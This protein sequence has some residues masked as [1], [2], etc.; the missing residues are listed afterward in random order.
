MG[1]DIQTL[2]WRRPLVPDWNRRYDALWAQLANAD[3]VSQTDAATLSVEACVL[4]NQRLGPLEQIKINKLAARLW[5]V[6]ASGTLRR[7]RIAIFG[8]ATLSLFAAH[9]KGSALARGM[10][11]DTVES[12]FGTVT[13]FA[14][15]AAQST[16]E[17]PLDAALLSLDATA[18]ARA[19]RLLDIVKDA[20]V[21]EAAAERLRAL[22]VGV[23]TR[24]GVPVIVATV[25]AQPEDAISS[26]EH[27]LLGSPARLVAAVNDEVRR[28]AEAGDW[29]MWDA[30]AL[31][32]E[33]GLHSW[34]DPVGRHHAKTPFASELCPIAA[35]HLCRVLAAM[36]GK[37]GRALVLDLDNTIWG[38][39]VGDDGVDGIQLGNGS[40]VGEAF[41]AVQRLALEL[42]RRGVVLAV[43]SKNNEDVARRPFQEHPDM[44]LRL[45]DI[46]VFQA[47]WVDKATNLKAIADALKLG[48]DAL[49][50]VDDNP[51]ERER[52]RQQWPLAIVPELG[53]EPAYFPRLIVASGA[54]EHLPLAAEDV[55]RAGDYQA[56]VSRQVQRDAAKDYDTY[57]GSLQMRMTITPFDRIGRARITQLINKSNQFN[58]TTRRYNEHDVARL[59]GDPA[60][61]AWQVRLSDTFADN[62]MIAVVIVHKEAAVRWRIDTWLMSCRVLER[63]VEQTIMKELVD[64]ARSQGCEE[65]WGEF[66]KTERNALVTDFYDRMTFKPV[67]PAASNGDKRYVLKVSEFALLKS[68]IEVS[69]SA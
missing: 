20:E 65:L 61:L 69:Q 41:L 48:I 27:A 24:L 63:G 16:I 53:E 15:G 14:M 59:E 33:I 21:R 32:G 12:D 66:L 10:L 2:P 5:K 49:V 22:A 47:N 36:T 51:V 68:F 4:A 46:A 56:T 62:G 31:A 42:R 28:G 52:V 19:E 40:A 8:N 30:A 1:F 58:L 6:A 34:F 23:R 17:G 67:E 39:V 35:D 45:K 29:L 37:S 43:C 3:Q 9:L 54:F 60:F 55:L 64:L 38:G 50:F 13:A 11:L 25:P 7:V 44:L 57:L 18:F 26:I